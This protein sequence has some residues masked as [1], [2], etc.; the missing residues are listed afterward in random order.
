MVFPAVI[1]GMLGGLIPMVV[2]AIAG[3]KT[4]EEARSAIYPKR[5]EMVERLIGSGMPRAAA[6][7]QVDE[8]LKSEVQ[9]KMQEGALPGWAT[10]AL[11]LAGGIG[12]GAL[13][14]KVGKMLAKK[15]VAAAK[16]ADE[17]AAAIT[18]TPEM[19]PVNHPVKP[20]PEIPDPVKRPA[21]PPEPEILPQ[22]MPREVP[23]E[24]PLDDL[25]MPFSPR[26]KPRQVVYEPFTD[27]PPL[28]D[29]IMPAVVN[30][31][32]A[33]PLRAPFAPAARRPKGMAAE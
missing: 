18:K 32:I 14:A 4:E 30:A 5:M 8:A 2:D 3:S 11:S 23:G 27:E 7:A 22:N 19:A 6:E 20:S 17:G 12:G 16:Q 13:G 10:A 1:G 25:V 29:D 21:L 28:P 15:P 31:P 9:S 33:A 26:Q 24:S